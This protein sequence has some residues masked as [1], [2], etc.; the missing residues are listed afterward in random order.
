MD[1]GIPPG[2][3]EVSL[4]DDASKKVVIKTFNN[5]MQFTTPNFKHA[6]AVIVVNYDNTTIVAEIGVWSY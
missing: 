1:E 4:Y 2:Y 5:L 3:P 6:G